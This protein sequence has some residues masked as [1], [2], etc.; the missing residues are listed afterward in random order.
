MLLI[1][2]MFHFDQVFSSIGAE[3]DMSEKNHSGSRRKS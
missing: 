1:P 3:F 2:E